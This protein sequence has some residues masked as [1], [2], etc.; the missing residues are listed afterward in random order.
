MTPPVDPVE[1]EPKGDHNRRLALGVDAEVFAA[2]AG[3]TVEALRAYEET[4]PDGDFDAEV[5]RRVGETLA[6]LEAVPPRTQK[7]VNQ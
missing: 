7:V 4:S 3:I 2:E 1:R 5:A 6:R